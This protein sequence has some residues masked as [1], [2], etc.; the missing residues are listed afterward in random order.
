M[1]SMIRLG[2]IYHGASWD[3]L[4]TDIILGT[5]TVTLIERIHIFMAITL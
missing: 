3:I 4:V 1:L 2:S 5:L